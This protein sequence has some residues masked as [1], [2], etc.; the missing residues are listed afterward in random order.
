M[1][2]RGGEGKRKRDKKRGIGNRRGKEKRD[3]PLTRCNVRRSDH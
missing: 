1:E 3:H 2:G